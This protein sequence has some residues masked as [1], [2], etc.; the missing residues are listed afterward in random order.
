MGTLD[1][2]FVLYLL[3]CFSIIWK[4]IIININAEETRNKVAGIL[5][6][7]KGT[8]DGVRA[9]T[10]LAPVALVVVTDE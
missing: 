9:C 2:P 1:H 7:C 6:T 4:I 5:G 3:I 10:S 8:I